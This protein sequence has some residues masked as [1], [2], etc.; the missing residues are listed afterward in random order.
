MKLILK[1]SHKNILIGLIAVCFLS[2]ATI[3]SLRYYEKET[4]KETLNLYLNNIYSFNYDKASEFQLS[5]RKNPLNN[6]NIKNLYI[7]KK[8]SK[9]YQN[10]I[11]DIQKKE[12][13]YTITIKENIPLYQ[14]IINNFIRL[15]IQQ[16]N[17]G[18]MPESDFEER[19]LNYV[20]DLVLTNSYKDLT[21]EEINK[22][23]LIKKNDIWLIK[24]D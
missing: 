11:L 16:Q 3:Y 19:L 21:F 13:T 18:Y 12:N 10:E 1:L 14:E 15:D 24:N 2:T 7:L 9:V 8:I 22:Y 17:L 6:K 20:N 4:V 5:K 23:T